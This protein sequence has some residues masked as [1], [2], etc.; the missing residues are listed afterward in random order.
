[1]RALSRI[2]QRVH[3][4]R[5]VAAP[6]NTLGRVEIYRQIQLAIRSSISNTI[7]LDH[8]AKAEGLRSQMIEA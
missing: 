5:T 6:L 3:S 4:E 8:V 7:W 1:M 2:I